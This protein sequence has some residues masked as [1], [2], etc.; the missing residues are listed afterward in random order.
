MTDKRAY[1]KKGMTEPSPPLCRP[2]PAAN[3]QT[4]PSK[5]GR[6]LGLAPEGVDRQFWPLWRAHVL[7]GIGM[8]TG[9]SLGL[10][11][12]SGELHKTE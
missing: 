12:T 2:R 7:A 5:R 6:R 11:M 1:K 8:I 3:T 10:P 4:K 9:Y